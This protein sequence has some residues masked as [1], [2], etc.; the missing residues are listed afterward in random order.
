MKFLL[1]LI[2]LNCSTFQKEIKENEINFLKQKKIGLVGFFLPIADWISVFFPLTNCS[3][4]G[5]G[6]SDRYSWIDRGD[7]DPHSIN[8]SILR[9]LNSSTSD[10]FSSMSETD[11]NIECKTKIR[12]INSLG[13]GSLS[14][15]KYTHYDSIKPVEEKNSTHLK[16]MLKEYLR[17]NGIAAFDEVRY[18]INSNEENKL[19]NQTSDYFI[20]GEY[21]FAASCDIKNGFASLLC[22]TLFPSIF[23]GFFFPSISLNRN[24][25]D[26]YIYDRNFK[27]L[28]T[29]KTFDYNFNFISVVLKENFSEK[30]AEKD[31]KTLTL[32][33][34]KELYDFLIEYERKK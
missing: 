3:N 21:D 16:K 31:F 13:F 30:K 17:R 26:L 20:I 19:Q 6:Y 22:L 9:Y 29:I 27:H 28:K 2:I 1:L 12:T 5:H 32:K 4:Y 33:A 15:K 23:S 10:K 8:E 18:F 7:Y 24:E 34:S 14:I 25:L 11:L